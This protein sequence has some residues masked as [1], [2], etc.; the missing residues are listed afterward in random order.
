M[1]QMS[2]DRSQHTVLV[3]DDNPATRY[4]T[5]RLLRAAGFQTLEA[6]SGGEALQ[7]AAGG[8][9][10]VVL[11]VHLP[12]IDGFEVC[13]RLRAAPDTGKLPVIH[14]SAAFVRSEDKVTG[15]HAGADAYLVHP[16]EP[17]LLVATLQ[18][19]I[20]ARVA[21]EQL[22]L[23]RREE[24]ERE[25]VAR[26]SA[27]RQS[28]TKDDFIAVLSHELRTPLNAIMGWTE[29][30][31]RLPHGPDIRKGLEAIERN[32]KTQARLIADILDVSRVNAGKLRLYREP[33][34]PAQLVVE[35]IAA[36]RTSIDEKR[37]H[38]ATDVDAA[39]A[40]AWLDPARFQQVLWNL[41]TNAIK[42]SPAG[43]E[44]RVRLQRQGS[45]LRLSVQ[46]F[47]QGVAPEFLAHLFDRFAQG[48][49][50]ANRVHGGLGLG[51]AIVQH[52]ADLHGGGV[53]ASSA[54]PGQG[55]TVEVEL[56]VAPPASDDEKPAAGV[57]AAPAEQGFDVL[58]GL[59]VLV[60]EDD[61]DARAMLQVVLGDCGCSVRAVA[62]YPAALRALDE[63]WPD[64]VVSD[65]G[66]G[67]HD[68]YELAREVR[69]RE[70]PGAHVP[71]V[72]V[73]AFVRDEDRDTAL[74]AGFDAHVGKPLKPHVLLSALA[75]LLSPR[76]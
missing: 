7:I 72:A 53:S 46:D 36:L 37:M 24:I 19:L 2:I 62:D 31:L 23:R 15:L 69:Q 35:S 66:L 49:A 56:D 34:D 47:G 41:M 25:Q 70:K 9:S 29:V 38:V 67:R 5:A 64:A 3:V 51:L 54:G 59:D 18:A 39:H 45:T 4:S 17:D 44:I 60:V 50:L 55:T 13:R 74:Q 43:S 12:D 11:D 68:G 6:A 52:L 1:I 8:V 30:L 63:R 10:A 73:T 21:E 71:M 58:R 61:A 32:V 20:R 75:A 76:P 65:I 27:E 14:L 48:D 42:F 26:A 28:R 57:A 33:V 22:E 16:V 40:V